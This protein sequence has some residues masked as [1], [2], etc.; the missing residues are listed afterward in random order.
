MQRINIDIETFSSIDIKKAGLYKYVESPDFQVLLFAYAI[1]FGAV[2]VVDLVNGEQIPAAV[3]DALFN[4]NIT[5]H[6]YNAVF[7]WCCL[8]KHFSIQ[9]KYTWLTHWHCTMVQGL[10]CGYPGGLA[11]I[12]EAMQ[13][14]INKKKMSVGNALIKTFCVPAKPTTL[15]AKRIL[16]HHEPDK[17]QLFKEYCAKDVTAEMGV[18]NKLSNFPVPLTERHLWLLDVRINAEGVLI[19]HEFLDGALYCSMKITDEL[20]SE[21]IRLSS[22]DNPKSVGQLKKWLEDEIGEEIDNLQKDNVS[23]LLNTTH[24]EKVKRVLEIRQELS[25]ASIKKYDAMKNVQGED[26]RAKGLLQYYGANRTGRWAGRLIQV[27]NLPRNYLSTLDLARELVK[28]WKLTHL[29][30][31]YGNVSD[32]LSQLIRTAFIPGEGSTFVVADFSAIEARVLSWLADEKWRLNVF[33]GHGKIYEASASQ[34]FGVEVEKI[35]KG[36]PEYELRQKGK[37]AELALGY[38]G[39]VGALKQMGALNMGLTGDELPELVSRWRNSNKRIVDLWYSLENAAV[40]VIRTGRPVGVRGLILAREVDLKNSQDFFTV[41]LPNSRKLYYVN[42]FLATNDFGKDALHYYGTENKKWGVINTYGGKLTEN[43]TQ[44]I[45]R[46]CLAES[47]INL[48]HA[49]YKI[50]MHIHDEIVLEVPKDK[51]NLT[52]VC[53]IMSRAVPWAPDLPLDAAGFVTE[54]YRKD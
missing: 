16:P 23:K 19:D 5:K 42:P 33:K 3:V 28:Q 29:K 9:D 34:M 21:A 13:L 36:N 31:L 10:Y 38:Q 30:T 6:A 44:A 17:W 27:Q 1:D 49:G 40:Q 43:I 7:E 53:S 26:D 8:S 52:E 51:I 18:L 15:N 12:S 22:L 47:L 20:M 35:V 4:P 24:N 46:D 41:T 14:P 11:A 2:T 54:F 37:V 50:V 39:G 32:T 45:A 25:K 48:H